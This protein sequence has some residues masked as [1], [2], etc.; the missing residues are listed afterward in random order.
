MDEHGYR[1][2][3]PANRGTRRSPSEPFLDF[4]SGYVLRSIDQFPKQGSKVPWRLHQNYAFDIRML[5]FG[6]LEDGALRFSSPAGRVQP[7][8]PVAA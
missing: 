2:C 6:E 3:M 7:P 5:R 1:Q 8:E 4:P